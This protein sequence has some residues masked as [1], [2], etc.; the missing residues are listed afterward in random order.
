MK[1][2][3]TLERLCELTDTVMRR[4]FCNK[5]PADC[6][7]HFALRDHSS[8]S[9]KIVRFIEQSVKEKIERIEKE[10]DKS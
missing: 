1:R 7:C 8:T 4:V 10:V 6:F 9:E 2:D 5:E 3:Q